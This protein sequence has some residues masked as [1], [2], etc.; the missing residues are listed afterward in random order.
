[1]SSGCSQQDEKERNRPIALIRIIRQKINV[2]YVIVENKNIFFIP[3]ENTPV[4][5]HVFLSLQ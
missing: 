1:M 5:D 3:V 2:F 4:L